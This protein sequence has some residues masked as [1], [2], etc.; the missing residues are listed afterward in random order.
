MSCEFGENQAETIDQA[1]I[2]LLE[3][4]P[5]SVRAAMEPGDHIRFPPGPIGVIGRA[6]RQR[7]EKE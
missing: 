6:A 1:R 5:Q 4:E 3:F 7:A 2:L